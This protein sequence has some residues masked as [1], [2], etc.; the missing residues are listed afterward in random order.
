V[1]FAKINYVTLINYLR[2]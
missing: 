2:T 1:Q